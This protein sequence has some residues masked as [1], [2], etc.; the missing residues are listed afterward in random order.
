VVESVGCGLEKITPIT[1]LKIVTLFSDAS[2]N[3]DTTTRTRHA[4]N[5]F[6]RD[7]RCGNSFEQ[8][9]ARAPRCSHG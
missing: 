7:A 3:N 5:V 4:H 6:Q 2:M 8:E 9:K 1:E